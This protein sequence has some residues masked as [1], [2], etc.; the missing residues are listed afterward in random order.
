MIGQT[1]VNDPAW[2][3]D[4][5]RLN[6]V[7]RDINAEE[8][9]IRDTMLDMYGGT[10]Y[11]F[12]GLDVINGTVP[13]T[14]AVNPGRARDK[15]GFSIIV[16]ALVDN[17]PNVG[18]AAD[19]YL[20]IKH[21]W[22]Y[23]NPDA[24]VKSGIAYNRQRSDGYEINVAAVAHA[25]AAG[26][27][28][29]ARATAAGAGLWNYEME[30]S[31]SPDPWPRSCGAELDTWT[32]DFTYPGV[33]A[34]PVFMNRHGLAA[35][36]LWRVPFDFLVL[37]VGVIVNVAAAGATDINLWQNA[38]AHPA[39]PAGTYTLPAG[40]SEGAWYNP[41]GLTLA[42]PVQYYKDDLLRV[43]LNPPGLAPSDFV[44]TIAGRKTGNV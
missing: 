39:W 28:R 17:I 19:Q 22:T 7:Q 40:A 29:L 26:W 18:A 5:Y 12:G 4:Y 1:N 43:E 30:Y 16:P 25:E 38:V 44:V 13:G 37:K 42:G 20:A 3:K 21:A 35:L 34:G 10:P 33:P 36:N 11:I 32:I 31:A 9:A 41:A 8:Q 23:A 15:D 24:A 2:L 14:H 6:D 27:V